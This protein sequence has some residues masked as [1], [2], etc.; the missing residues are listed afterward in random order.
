MHIAFFNPAGDVLLALA[1]LFPQLE[2]E[3]SHFT[4]RE[5]LIPPPLTEFVP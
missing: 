4:E 5:M 3:L 2:A 1:R